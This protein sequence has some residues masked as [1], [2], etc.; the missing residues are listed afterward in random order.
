MQVYNCRTNKSSARPHPK[1]AGPQSAAERREEPRRSSR[2]PLCLPEAGTGPRG[3]GRVPTG[4]GRD[5]GRGERVPP[6]ARQ[7]R[8]RRDGG[9]VRR[10]LLGL[11]APP[12]FLSLD[13]P[14]S[15]IH[16]EVPDGYVVGH[17][18]GIRSSFQFCATPGPCHHIRSMSNAK[19]EDESDASQRLERSDAAFAR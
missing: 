5:E 2:G 6:A 4:K 14:A 8:R 11:L 15:G 1:P 17:E 3:A 12:I 19:I 7:A 9:F 10:T 13:A 16:L 18:L